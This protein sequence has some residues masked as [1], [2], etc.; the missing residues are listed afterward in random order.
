LD[1]QPAA[2]G[3]P[4]SQELAELVR[5]LEAGHSSDPPAWT[6]PGDPVDSSDATDG[7]SDDAASVAA[8]AAAGASAVTDGAILRPIPVVP[9][10]GWRRRL[11]RLTGGLVNPGVSAAQRAESELLAR[12]RQPLSGSYR[13]AVVSRKGGVGKTST[14][15]CLGHVFASLRTDRVVA[16]DANP[17][18]G[19][20]AR[21]VQRQSTETVTSLLAHSQDLDR[22]ADMRAFTSQSPSRLEV[23]ASDDDPCITEALGEQAYRRVI[24]LL[25]RHYTLLL[26][27]TGTGILDSAIQGVLA[28]SDQ[29]VVVAPAAVDGAWAAAATLDWLD[30]HGYARLVAGAVAVINGVT[31]RSGG[32][33]DTDRIGEQFADR[34]AAVH[35]VPFDAHLETGARVRPTD[36]RPATRQAYLQLAASV[37]DQLATARPRHNGR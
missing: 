33:V 29:L 30:A 19:S 7:R 35:R 25:D 4:P 8:A 16:L 5:R 37:A 14:T 6:D 3:A 20:L 10:R 17:D 18:A 34:V 21:R 15:V 22:Y 13:V 23:V 36:L 11:Y 28:E 26:C 31:N 27:D 1:P 12:V 2:G 24:G 9:R 32:R